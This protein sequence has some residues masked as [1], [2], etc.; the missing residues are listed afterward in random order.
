MDAVT[1]TT[2]TTKSTATDIIRVTNQPTTTGKILSKWKENRNCNQI[3]AYIHTYIYICMY[4][5]M[6]V[7]LSRVAQ[8]ANPIN[9]RVCPLCNT[10]EVEDEVHFLLVCPLYDSLREQFLP[11]VSSQSHGEW[12]VAVR[13]LFRDQG[14]L[15][16]AKF[17]Q[18]AMATRER[19]LSS[20][21]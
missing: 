21:L 5:Y 1:P 12:R 19:L 3:Y 8:W 11:E 2:T 20:R 15:P 7:Y 10:G 13:N 16:V 6:Y 17:I 9:D 4:A 14:T 18:T